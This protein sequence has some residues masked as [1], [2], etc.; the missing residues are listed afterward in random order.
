MTEMKAELSKKD[1]IFRDM[2]L[3]GNM[4]KSVAYV[5]IPLA[6]YQFA[7]QLFNI[8]DTMIASHI[9][10]N[11]ITAVTYF[12]QIVM[13]LSAIGGG[14][15]VGASIKISEAYG[16][17]DY[18]LV[19]S[20]VSS[21]YA[22]IGIFSILVL[23]SILPFT[24]KFLLM[25]STA[26][27]LILE[28]KNYFI[29]Q[30]IATVFLCFNSVYFSIERIRGNSKRILYIN[31]I[32][33]LIKFSLSAI[34]V[35]GMNGGI[36]HIAFATL[37]AQI[38]IFII[39]MF[40]MNDKNNAFGFSFKAISFRRKI[41]APMVLMSIPVMSEK[42]AFS[43]G[44]VIVNIMSK[45]YGINT[46]GALGVSNTIGG[47]TTSVQ[48]GFQE[49]GVAIISQ[50]MGA[51]KYDRVMDA[52]KKMLIINVII[53]FTGFVLTTVFLDNISGIFAKN[54]IE[55]KILISNIYKYEAFGAITLGI[56]AAVMALLY[57]LGLTKL[58][59]ILN[60]L[61][62]F[63]FRIPVL[64][65]LQ[66]FTNLGS[67]SVGIVMMVSNVSVGIISGITGIIVINKFKNYHKL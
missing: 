58:T 13:M 57:G 66:H 16:A 23:A 27:E 63:V 28:G 41:S 6:I 17:G 32:A 29:I 24:E 37:S 31:M 2:S 51:K 55:F 38:F 18:K 11:S 48:K 1:I 42:L 35:Y 20:R 60:I 8:L 12:S 3:N 30:L 53:G 61:R 44:K 40:N 34:F 14:L 7:T 47:A 39:A 59:L 4:W 10:A 67:S 9:S 62:V 45:G 46:V 64:W 19:R 50:N 43:F 33:I 52:F 54:N 25:T 65:C 26:S 15:S 36:T 56:N 22:I 5:C 49:G 21:L